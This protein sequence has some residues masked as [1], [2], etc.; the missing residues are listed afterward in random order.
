MSVHVHVFACAC[1]LHVHAFA[2]DVSVY[3]SMCCM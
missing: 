1:V 2:C 3:V